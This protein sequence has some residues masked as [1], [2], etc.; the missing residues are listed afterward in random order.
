MPLMYSPSP[1]DE[2]ILAVRCAAEEACP[3]LASSDDQDHTLPRSKSSDESRPVDDLQREKNKLAQRRYRAKRKEQLTSN[4]RQ[5]EELS[6]KLHELALHNVDLQRRQTQLSSVA[7]MQE[8]HITR[9]QHNQTVREVEADI[10]L[11]ELTKLMSRV[12]G[13]SFSA[14]EAKQWTMEMWVTTHF[15]SY[16]ERLKQLLPAARADSS[17]AAAR[18]LNQLVTMRREADTRS[19]MFSSLYWIIWAWNVHNTSATDAQL[20][21]ARSQPRDLLAGLDLTQRQQR[22]MLAARERLLACLAD[23]AQ[24]RRAALSALGLAMLH[25]SD[26]AK[27]YRCEA[28]ADLHASLEEERDVVH[29]FLFKV[30]EEILTPVQEAWLDSQLHPWHPDVWTITNQLA[31]HHGLPPAPDFPELESGPEDFMPAAP[32][33]HILKTPV[34]AYGIGLR[35]K[36]SVLEWHFLSTHRVSPISGLI[37]ELP[38]VGH[39]SSMTLYEAQMG[40]YRRYWKRDP[41]TVCQM[42]LPAYLAEQTTRTRSSSPPAVDGITPVF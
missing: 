4:R 18:E 27:L 10:L 33:Y 17:C 37:Y 34:V 35:L 22:D 19:A 40:T 38:K 3:M 20:D 8:Q 21:L 42:D 41:Y 25:E 13:R 28:A 26:K 14:A 6:A 29:T 12:A 30:T 36:R 1:V 7:H 31:A 16:I 15:Q 32:P 24:K 9:M 23:V 11:E 39:M 2:P 5:L